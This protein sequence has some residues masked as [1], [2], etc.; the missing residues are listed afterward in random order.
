MTESALAKAQEMAAAVTD[1]LGGWGLFGVELFVKGNEVIF[2]E[3]S[4]RPHDTGLVTLGS[5]ALSEFALH[6]R[7]ITGLPVPDVGFL[8]PAASAVVLASEP[9]SAPA[10][11]G[12]DDA[13][14]GPDIHLRLFG[15]PEAPGRRRMGVVVATAGDVDTA[16]TN[17][18]AAAAKIA[19]VDGADGRHAAVATSQAA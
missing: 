13:V 2:S 5:Q 4:P 1:A 10:F 16:R 7:A 12:V 18:K 17:A 6:V 8:T 11:S 9:T 15:K 3:V 19:V 14:T